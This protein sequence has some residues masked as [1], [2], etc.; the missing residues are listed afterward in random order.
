MLSLFTDKTKEFGDILTGTNE[1]N[2]KK[3]DNISNV[4]LRDLQWEKN[5]N[6]DK[7]LTF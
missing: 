3:Y 6:T 4:T 5:T 7:V 1:I 2:I